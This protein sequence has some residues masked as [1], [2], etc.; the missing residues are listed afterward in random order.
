VAFSFVVLVPPLLA[1]TNPISADDIPPLRPVRPEIPPS[2][3]EQNG[4][5]VVIA[6]GSCVL[7]VAA[8]VWL[9]VRPKPPVPVP[10]AVQA[11]RELEPLRQQ[12][13]DGALLSR[14]SQVL[15]R[16]V[17]AAFGLPTGELTTAEFSRAIDG[18]EQIGPELSAACLDFLRQCDQRKFAPIP[19]LPPLGAVSRALQLIEIAEARLATLAQPPDQTSVAVE[20]RPADKE[21]VE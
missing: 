8:V 1:A 3:W 5:G 7:L 4:L 11:R 19:P 17:A 14:V 13:E 21:V 6:A 15:R 9:L 16:Y 18:Y 10:P 2:F 12:P 20:T